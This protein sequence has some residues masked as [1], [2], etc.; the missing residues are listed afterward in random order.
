MPIDVRIISATNRDLKTEIENGNFRE[1]LYYR[2]NVV[3][4][5]LPPLRDRAEYIPLLA[6]HFLETH[7]ARQGRSFEGFDDDADRAMSRYP[8]PGNVRELENAIQRAIALA[9][10][11]RI[12]AEDLALPRVGGRTAGP[13]RTLKEMERELVLK[14]LDALGGNVSEAAR[15]LGVSRR[16][17]HYRLRDWKDEADR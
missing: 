3:S 5:E 8:W 12:G 2:L 6:R 1:D 14:T 15:T 13:G 10:G 7:A 17:L 11:K 16:W 9:K 4:I